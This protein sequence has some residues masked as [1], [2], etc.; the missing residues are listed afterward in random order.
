M[1]EAAAL[2]LTNICLDVQ[3]SICMYLHP[4]D[5]LALRNVC[6]SLEV[7]VGRISQVFHN[8]SNNSNAGLK[9]CVSIPHHP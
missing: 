1:A 5:V 2:A 7:F 6:R 8:Y 9:R 3:I 4:S